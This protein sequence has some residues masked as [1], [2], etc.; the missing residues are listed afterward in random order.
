MLFSGDP[1]FWSRIIQEIYGSENNTKHSSP[2]LSYGLKFPQKW[3]FKQIIIANP[4]GIL[5]LYYKTQ[6]IQNLPT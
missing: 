1:T 4:S 5:S 2:G 6:V 3:N